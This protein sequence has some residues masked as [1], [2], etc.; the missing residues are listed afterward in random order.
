MLEYPGR[1]EGVD[2]H[3]DAL[4]KMYDIQVITPIFG[5]GVK[6]GENDPLTLIRPSSIRGHLRFW[7]RTIRGTKFETAERLRLREGE[8]WGTTES[9]SN[10]IVEVSI[11]SIGSTY[12][13]AYTPEGKSFPRFEK[14][15]PSYA[16]FPFQGNKKDGTPIAKCTSNIS[17]ILKLTCPRDIA[18]DM[19]AAIWAWTNFGGIGARTRRGC[20]ALYCKEL[21]PSDKNSIRFW[22]ESRLKS[23]GA[24][25]SNECEWP[26]LP[27]GF[28]VRDNRIA[29]VL[30]NWSEVIG[31]MQTFR[32]GQNVGR[33]PGTGQN[34]PGRSRWPEPETIREASSSRSTRHP[35]IAAIPDDAF[36]RAEFGLP[37]VF[38]F[39]DVGDP[40]D[41][42]L[43]PVISGREKTR[44][45]SPLIIR[46]MI[47]ADGSVLQI[48]L[49]LKTDSP[50][51][52][53]LR[54][55][56]KNPLFK[57][58]SDPGL[59]TYPKSPM[60]S[61]GPGKP[62]RSPSG[63]AIEAFISFAKEKGNDFVEV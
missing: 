47:C 49:R 45:S 62:V 5:G 21:S 37:L 17:F 6:A 31:L 25:M 48:I 29:D 24:V 59:A 10:V 40:K 38:H 9:P 8:I 41:T 13:C 36:P 7:W 50:E 12:P 53:I 11:R 22:Y 28:L 34:R 2:P 60:G 30:Q 63:S 18:S 14:N 32:Q 1:P 19:E 15:H 23:F 46:P 20:G 55:A 35:R 39:K 4:V 43:Y 52:V 26:I 27:E 44:M 54:K 3:P 58:I 16:L 42:E 57:K 56:P 51:E 61:S 33:N